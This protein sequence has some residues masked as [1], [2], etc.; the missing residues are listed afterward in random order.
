M[1][2]YYEP[3]NYLC[4]ITDHRLGT[5]Q[6]GKPQW[7]L[8][9][10]VQAFLLNGNEEA[11]SQSE[12]RIYRVITDNTFQYLKD[13]V[14]HLMTLGEISGDVT[15]FEALD[16][17]N[18]GALDFR[19]VKFEAYCKHEEYQGD[20]KERWQISSG[21]REVEPLDNSELR[22]LNNLFGKELR[23]LSRKGDQKPQSEPS[24]VPP[25]EGD[26]IPF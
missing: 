20:I 1:S 25:D 4:E 21:K 10:I 13:D 12:R 16:L 2:A 5:T 6:T 17:G 14:E 7:V 15:G 22:K 9:F 11:V 23:K 26:D 18:P 24:M 19:G 8:T 3:G